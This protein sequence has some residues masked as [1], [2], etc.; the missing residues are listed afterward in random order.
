MRAF[1]SS[2]VSFNINMSAEASATK[3]YIKRVLIIGI[4]YLPFMQLLRRELV[5]SASLLSCFRV[6]SSAHP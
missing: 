5:I 3:M 6:S 1:V 4:C 2:C